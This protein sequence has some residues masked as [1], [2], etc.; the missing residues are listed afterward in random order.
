MGLR[1]ARIAADNCKDQAKEARSGT[2]LE[3]RHRARQDRAER[4]AVP[5]VA[6]FAARW[7][8][9]PP[10][11][12]GRNGRVS[13]RTLRERRRIL[14]R[15]VL[16]H[17]G[18]MRIKLVSRELVA[19]VID[20]KAT[21]GARRELHKLLH[22]LFE[23][24]IEERVVDANPVAGRRIPPYQPKDRNLDPD[25]IRAFLE[26]LARSK[27]T[28]AMQLLLKTVLY[29]GCRT[30]EAR[31]AR[32][33]D[34]D[35]R[36]RVWRIPETKSGPAREVLLS[37]QMEA[38]FEFA[39]GVRLN[40]AP[41]A[42][43]FASGTDEAGNDLPFGESA[44][45]RLLARLQKR[46]TERLREITGNADREPHPFSP[47]D[48]RRT[49]ATRMSKIGVRHEII[50]SILDHAPTG[51]TGRVYI[52]GVSDADRSEAWQRLAD[53]I[54]AACAGNVAPPTNVVMLRA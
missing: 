16:P 52:Q 15:D 5:T 32:W 51:V 8:D 41:G 34:V 2:G 49:A 1:E 3:P 12:G 40:K 38:L 26:A 53:D 9:A 28:L 13:D 10:R 42:L 30:G 50:S 47:H 4:L 22:A 43:V 21:D 14:D 19:D 44:T 20:R 6:E 39:R 24:A 54:D 29:S 45:S 17:I 33:K 36:G 37:R 18:P 7:L 27:A 48:L 31:L 23:Y 46:F 11:R 35:L 25:E